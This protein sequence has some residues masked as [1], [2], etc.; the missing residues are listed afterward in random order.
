MAH[1]RA[2]IL[3]V[4]AMSALGQKRTCAAQYVMS[5]LP[6]IADINCHTTSSGLYPIWQ[7]SISSRGS[8]TKLQTLRDDFQIATVKCQR[9]NAKMDEAKMA[10]KARGT[11]WK[12]L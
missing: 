9:K 10:V 12:H 1:N 5:A 6:P 11:T 3:S 4:G 8:S 2:S 7:N